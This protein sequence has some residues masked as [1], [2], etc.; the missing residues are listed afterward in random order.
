MIGFVHNVFRGIFFCME[1]KKDCPFQNNLFVYIVFLL[2][3][4]ARLGGLLLYSSFMDVK[5]SSIELARI[6][7]VFMNSIASSEFIPPR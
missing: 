3:S 5:N 2:L 6:K 4:L 1:Q 7:R